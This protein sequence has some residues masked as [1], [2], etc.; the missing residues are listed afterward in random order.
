M[1]RDKSRDSEI[2]ESRDLKKGNNGYRKCDLNCSTNH[3][4]GFHEGLEL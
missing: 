2:G 3:K 1:D 4:M